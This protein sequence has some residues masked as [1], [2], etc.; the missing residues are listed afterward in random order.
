VQ[1]LSSKK[2]DSENGNTTPAPAAANDVADD[3]PF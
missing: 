1:L 3:L 2:D